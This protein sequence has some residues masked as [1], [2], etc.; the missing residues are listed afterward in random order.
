MEVNYSYLTN[1]DKIFIFQTNKDADNYKLVSIDIGNPDPTTWK[2]LVPENEKDVLQWASVANEKYLILGYTQDVKSVVQLHELATGKLI[3]KFP[4]EIGTVSGGDFSSDIRYKDIFFNFVSF[5]TPGIIYHCDLSKPP[6]DLEILREI[7]LKDFDRE[8]YAAEQVFFKS[9]DGT[10]IPMFITYKKGLQKT[11]NNFV[12]MTAY[13]G[14]SCTR[15]PYFAP[16]R[17]VVI[18]NFDGIHA[19]PNIRG[20]GE[21]GEKWH[22]DGSLDKKQNSFDDFQAAAEYLIAEKY[23]NSKLI[24]INGGSN[25]GLLMGACLNQR[26]DLFGAVVADVGVFDMLRFDKFT[27]G[28]AW[29][30]EYGTSSKEKDFQYLIKYS[31]LHNIKM[32]DDPNKQYP[33][34][35]LTTSDHDDRVSPLHSLKFIATLQFEAKI[36]STQQNPLIIKVETDAGHG[37]GKPLDKIIA[38]LVDM[39]CFIVLN[40]GIKFHPGY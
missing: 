38:E 5:L 32:S 31:P 23:T 34:T 30:T 17:I 10:S 14:F 35:M 8:K 25:G 7:K 3:K 12:F 18:D 6:F 40:T 4:L 1:N 16:N 21:Y 11:G 15:L 24:A 22:R 26:P 20:G 36:H 19:V 33:A 9:K 13:G 29:V 39:M 37:C 28:H 27:I 2:D